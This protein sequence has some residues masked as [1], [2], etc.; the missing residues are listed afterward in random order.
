M[1][2][3]VID[4]KFLLLREKIYF[5]STFWNFPLWF[6]KSFVSLTYFTCFSFPLSLTMMHHTMHVLDAPALE[7]PLST[8]R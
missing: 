6:R 3:L 1:N 5:P 4:S 2:F 7:Y 8:R